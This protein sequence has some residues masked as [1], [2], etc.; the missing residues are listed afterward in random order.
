MFLAIFSFSCWVGSVSINPNYLVGN[1]DWWVSDGLQWCFC[2]L[3]YLTK[4][5]FSRWKHI[6]VSYWIF[7]SSCSWKHYLSVLMW[8]FCCLFC[9]WFSG[10]GFQM[11]VTALNICSN[12]RL[13]LSSFLHGL[14][15]INSTRGWKFH[16]LKLW[17]ETNNIDVYVFFCF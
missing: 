10:L 5:N 7:F 8:Q 17:S 16:H 9:A 12:T 11:V 13:Q 2:K 14:A 3:S 6:N 1:I 4:R 15:V